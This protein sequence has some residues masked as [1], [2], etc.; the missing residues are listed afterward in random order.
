[1]EFGYGLSYTTFQLSNLRIDKQEMAVD[2]ELTLTIDVT[3]TGLR[4][5]AETVQLYISDLKSSLPRPVKELKG[6]QKV[7]LKPGE[8]QT[9]SFTI[10]RSAL[11]FYND[12]TNSWTVEPGE[13]VAMLN[14]SSS[15]SNQKVRFTV[16]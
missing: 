16:K 14:N 11:S 13:F 5:G 7:F 6:F 4:A 12:R 2:D 9:V 8:T 3:N 1:M 15:P 10:E